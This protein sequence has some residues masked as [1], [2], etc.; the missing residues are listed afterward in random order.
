MP[1]CHTLP[2]KLIWQLDSWYSSKFDNR[3]WPPWIFLPQKQTTST[4]WN[5]LF[6]CK[7]IWHANSMGHF[8]IRKRIGFH[9]D[10]HAAKRKPSLHKYSLLMHG[11][12][13]E[14]FVKFIFEWKKLTVGLS[15][16]NICI[17]F[18]Y[19]RGFIIVQ[20]FRPWLKHNGL[21]NPIRVL[22]CMGN[23]DSYVRIRVLIM[24]FSNKNVYFSISV[25]KCWS[26]IDN[27]LHTMIF[28]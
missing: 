9:C 6:M 2:I 19:R 5:Q 21:P 7:T 28:I 1:V 16:C 14:S 27:L 25:K 23:S 12:R 18:M 10:F 22:R 13:F 24:N 26:K 20:L 11:I 4:M 15:V 8:I 3:N 17:I